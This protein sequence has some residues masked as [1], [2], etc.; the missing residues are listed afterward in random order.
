MV[1]KWQRYIYVGRRCH[2]HRS[3][4]N[5]RLRLTLEASV[6]ESISRVYQSLF[7]DKYDGI[8]AIMTLETAHGL[9]LSERFSLNGEANRPY[10]REKSTTRKMTEKVLTMSHNTSKNFAALQFI[11]LSYCSS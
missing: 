11:F 7:T 10:D 4:L 1:T 8:S 2:S 5:P 6:S 9:A 3:W